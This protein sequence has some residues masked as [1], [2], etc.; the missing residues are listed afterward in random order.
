MLYWNA[1]LVRL[2]ALD[3]PFLSPRYMLIYIMYARVEWVHSS[4]KEG[5]QI[6]IVARCVA[7]VVD[8]RSSIG[9]PCV[10]LLVGV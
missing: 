9:L 2:C 5:E 3:L 8:G 1:L 4:P 10:A 7:L 6:C